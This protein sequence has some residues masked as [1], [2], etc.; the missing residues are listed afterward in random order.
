[1][2]SE[3]KVSM[4]NTKKWYGDAEE[5]WK[6]VPATV[7]GMLGG[8]AYVSPPDIEGSKIFLK[9]FLEEP[10]ALIK[11]DYALDCG[12]GIGRITKHLLLPLFKKVDMVEQNK[13]FLD[14]A[15]QYLGEDNCSRVEQMIC[16]GLQDFKPQNCRYNVI[17]CQWVL[18]HLTDGHL[19]DFLK[20]CM[21]GLSK[22]G[23]IVVKENVTSNKCII[24]EDDSSV[25]RTNRKFQTL[26]NKAGLT[27][28]KE[29]IQ[30]NFPEELFKVKM[31]ALR[32]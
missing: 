32:P 30:R 11:P 2:A 13:M 19:I 18:S 20:R 15:P 24:D 8:L 10:N 16:S 23:L 4:E 27:I 5:Y 6:N 14:K 9:E 21:N 28:V 31:Y 25:T 22:N 17:W 3:K 12:S 26:F 1:M 7:D 29:D